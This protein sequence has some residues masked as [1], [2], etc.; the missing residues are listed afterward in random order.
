MVSSL[1][2]CRHIEG[3]TLL[4]EYEACF[5]SRKRMKVASS[6]VPDKDHLSDVESS[7]ELSLG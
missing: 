6:V 2:C 5:S 3:T 7:M 1:L 4:H